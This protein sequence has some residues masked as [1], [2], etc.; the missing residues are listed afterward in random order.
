M[1]CECGAE[2]ICAME[3]AVVLLDVPL[4]D[5]LQFGGPTVVFPDGFT[6]PINRVVYHDDGDFIGEWT[7]QMTKD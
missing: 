7:F 4:E 2:A 6:V 3:D 1:G 5:R